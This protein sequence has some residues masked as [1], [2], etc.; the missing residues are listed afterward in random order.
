MRQPHGVAP[1]TARLEPWMEQVLADADGC[2]ALLEEYG[3]PVNLLDLAA[4]RRN[5]EE[6]AEPARRHG[7]DLLIQVARKANKA[8]AV[9]DAAREL[10]LGIDVGGQDELLQVLG[11][12]VDPR[13]VVLTAAV[14][15][16]SLLRL[17]LEHDV[18][19][20]LDNLDEAE[21]LSGLARQQ[22]VRARVA[23]R[24]APDPDSG[25]PPSRFGLLAEQW[26]QWLAGAPAV[27]VEGIHFHL[28][29]YAALDRVTMLGRALVL[30]DE[31]R[32]RGHHP[33]NIDIG[34]GVPMSYLDDGQQW[35]D[36]WTAHHAALETGQPITWRGHPLSNVYPYHQA[37]V[38]GVW[39]DEVL[40]AGLLGGS[41]AEQLRGRGL[42]LRC[43][44]GR[45]ML[46]GCGMTLARV[47]MRKQTSDGLDLVGLEMNRTQCRSTSDDFMVDPLLARPGTA[48]A[49]SDP[50]EAWLVGAYCIE[51]ELILQRRIAFPDGVAVG[52][53]IALPN[54]G[55]Y[56]M[57]IL[58]SASHQMPLARNLVRGTDGGFR[59]DAIDLGGT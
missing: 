17:C 24:I 56:L 15:P 3:S 31:L 29:G 34:G 38:R 18:L 26:L 1:L 43:E 50:V 16:I 9:V 49:P 46:D 10:G 27:E 20:A 45:A 11:R 39:L 54:T 55:G 30:V 4:L 7:V 6:L 41:V 32:A 21:E 37:P 52:D 2:S 22:G 14:K 33:S 28:H 47:V 8:L 42:Q 59:L 44:P 36:F 35:Q 48:G 53:V 12:G 5:A 40:G 51:A 57:H 23:L 13:R 58:E 19:C 25:L